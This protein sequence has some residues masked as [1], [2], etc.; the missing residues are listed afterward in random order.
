MGNAGGKD[1]AF[2]VFAKQSPNLIRLALTGVKWVEI[3]GV[4][5]RNEDDQSDDE[6]GD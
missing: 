3:Q 5:A 6:T 1:K 4:K 2:F